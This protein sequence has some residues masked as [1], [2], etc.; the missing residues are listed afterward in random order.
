[1]LRGRLQRRLQAA[2]ERGEHSHMIDYLLFEPE[3]QLPLDAPGLRADIEL[4][5]E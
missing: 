3:E 1:M 4:H 5:L 2:D